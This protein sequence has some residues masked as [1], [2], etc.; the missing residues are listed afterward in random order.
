V[1]SAQDTHAAG[2]GHLPQGEH[3]TDRR[4]LRHGAAQEDADGSEDW[5]DA[6][7]RSLPVLIFAVADFPPL[8]KLYS[9]LF[10]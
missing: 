1:S 3:D 4:A 10:D 6:R 7:S 2:A 8:S 5:T 9:L